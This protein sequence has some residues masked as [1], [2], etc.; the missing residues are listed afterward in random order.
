[1]ARTRLS[2][3][4]IEQIVGLLT[5]WTGELSWELVVIRVKALLKRPFTRQGLDKQQPI[6]FAFKQA[7]TRL[8]TRPRKVKLGAEDGM[9]PE[10]AAAQ[11]QIDNLRAE[12]KVL[13]AEKNALLERFATWT[14]NARSRGLSEEALNRKL[15]PVDRRPSEK[16]T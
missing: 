9:S 16:K 6:R 13:K 8:R 5:S 14:Y 4:E 15:P 12:I 1:M 7:K 2:D 10:L 3:Q 11:R